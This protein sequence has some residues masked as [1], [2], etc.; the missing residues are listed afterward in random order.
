MIKRTNMSKI[1]K[2]GAIIVSHNDNNRIALLYRKK[3]N[4]WTFPKGHTEPGENSEQAMRREIMEETG[5]TITIVDTLPDQEYTGSN[6]ELCCVKMYL[7]RSNDDSKVK[8]EF[9]GDDIQW[10]PL[11]KVIDKLSYQN[12]KDYFP[13]ILP[14]ISNIK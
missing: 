11:D 13:S 1:P 9:K 2:A 3:L 12:L 10:V 6:D 4:D 8:R 7:V 5:L 14:I